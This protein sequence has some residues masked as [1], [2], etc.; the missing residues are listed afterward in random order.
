[1]SADGNIDKTAHEI[2][3]AGFKESP[4]RSRYSSVSVSSAQR[5]QPDQ[6]LAARSA[7]TALLCASST[8][9]SRPSHFVGARVARERPDHLVALIF[10]TCDARTESTPFFRSADLRSTRARSMAAGRASRQYV[11]NLL[12]FFEKRAASVAQRGPL[13]RLVIGKTTARVDL[14]ELSATKAGASAMLDR[15]VSRSGEAIRIDPALL[16]GQAASA[17]RLRRLQNHAAMYKRDTG[18]DGLYLDSHF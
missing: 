6:R 5:R 12:E 9:P 7:W 13:V 16:R 11:E 15:F 2:Q 14:D 17:D 10:S 18:I 1:M 4:P 3:A 8:L